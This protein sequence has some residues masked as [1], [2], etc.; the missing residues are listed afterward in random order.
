RAVREPFPLLERSLGPAASAWQ[1]GL[2]TASTHRQPR[3]T[4]AV[5]KPCPELFLRGT[6]VGSARCLATSRPETR[7]D[8]CGPMSVQERKHR[9]SNIRLFNPLARS[10][11]IAS[12]AGAALLAG[13]LTPVFAQ[14]APPSQKPPAAAAATSSK[15]E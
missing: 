15:P 12:V 3:A 5:I 10:L 2:A 11:A 6:V 7:R 9:M 8:R 14:N 1:P 4:A 13:S